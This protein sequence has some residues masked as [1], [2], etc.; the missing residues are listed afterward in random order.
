MLKTSQNLSGPA[1]TTIKTFQFIWSHPLFFLF[2]FFLNL[3]A[4]TNG[5]LFKLTHSFLASNK[6]HNNWK[7]CQ[8]AGSSWLH[9]KQWDAVRFFS[10]YL[11]FFQLTHSHQTSSCVH[12]CGWSPFDEVVNNQ[13]YNECTCSTLLIVN[14][15]Y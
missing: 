11:F 14:S 9:L 13:C 10:I 12:L 4:A 7:G 1:V 8:F 3:S 5:L 15:W 2:F 6:S